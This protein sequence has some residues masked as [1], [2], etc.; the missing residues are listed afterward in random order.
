M[1]FKVNVEDK[2][3]SAIF[4][5]HHYNIEPTDPHYK[6]T[7]GMDT[8]IQ[9]KMKRRGA[10]DNAV[11]ESKKPKITEQQAEKRKDVELK[12]LVK[13]VKRKTQEMNQRK[14]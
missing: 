9:E 6:K 1:C 8:L 13:N 5:S 14:K 2:R 11:P 12:L 4:T 10:K 7:K 3:F